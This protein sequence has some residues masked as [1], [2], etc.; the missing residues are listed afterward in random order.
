MNADLKD[1]RGSEEASR[2]HLSTA[3]SERTNDSVTDEQSTH[4]RPLSP[5]VTASSFQELTWEKS[6]AV[7]FWA[8][9]D[10]YDRA[11]D[12]TIQSVASRFNGWVRFFSCDVDDSENFDLCKL[13]DITAIPCVVIFKSKR[14]S[15]RI[16]GVRTELDFAREV[17][18]GITQSA[19]PAKRSWWKRLFPSHDPRPS[20]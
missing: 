20:A 14:P 7:H 19:T 12:V 16:I 15:H 11:V 2:L 17:L 1:Y 18:V 10:A 13:L 4:W 3:M 6:I 9:W 8:S 5:S